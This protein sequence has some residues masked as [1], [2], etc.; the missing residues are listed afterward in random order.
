VRI[1]TLELAS[2]AWAAPILI[3]QGFE[4]QTCVTEDARILEFEAAGIDVALPKKNNTGGQSLQFAIDNVLGIAQQRIDEALEAGER[5]MMTCRVYVSS[6]LSF[7][8]ETPYRFVVQAG[9]MQGTTL[10]IRAGF[11]D[12]INT[13][14]PRDLYTLGFSPGVRY[15]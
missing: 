5:V 6:D 15:L 2:A 11:F 4:N 13:R 9:S 8:A 1:I 7:P 10:N 12:V 3:C 14:F